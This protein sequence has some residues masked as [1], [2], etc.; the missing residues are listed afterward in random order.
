MDLPVVPLRRCPFCASAVVNPME[1]QNAGQVYWAVVCGDCSAE[2]PAMRERTDAVEAWQRRGEET[3][4]SPPTHWHCAAHGA[5]DAFRAVG[6]PDCMR[7]ARQLL[8]QWIRHRM[9]AEDLIRQ[10]R[11]ALGTQEHAEPEDGVSAG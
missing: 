7:E 1:L 3:V 5:F 2:G 10:T 6:C 9:T 8:H 11:A 4:Q